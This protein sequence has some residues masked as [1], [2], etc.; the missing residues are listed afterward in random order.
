VN[1]ARKLNITSR[2][3]AFKGNERIRIMTANGPRRVGGGVL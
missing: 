2:E 3:P 1:S